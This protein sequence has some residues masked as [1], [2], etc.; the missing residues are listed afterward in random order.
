MGLFKGRV[1]ATA[2]PHGSHICRLEANLLHDF[3]PGLVGLASSWESKHQV[4]ISY[5]LGSYDVWWPQWL[6]NSAA[7]RGMHV[8]NLA[9]R[10]GSPSF[11]AILIRTS[12]LWLGSLSGSAGT[13]AFL[14]FGEPGEFSTRAVFSKHTAVSMP[15]YKYGLKNGIRHGPCVNLPQTPA[16]PLCMGPS[17]SQGDTTVFLWMQWHEEVGQPLFLAFM[18][19]GFVRSPSE[20]YLRTGRPSRPDRRCPAH[21]SRWILCALSLYAA[22]LLT[23]LIRHHCCLNDR[24]IQFLLLSVVEWQKWSGILQPSQVLSIVTGFALD[25]CKLC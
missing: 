18:A 19:T 5:A 8:R 22:S 15:N 7:L 11:F 25:K 6:P 2:Q 9:P 17:L 10:A 16:W 1:L 20:W 21:C 24:S 13:L 14:P 3:L 4:W 12:I 23:K